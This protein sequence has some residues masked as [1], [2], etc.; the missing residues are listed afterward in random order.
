MNY[1]TLKFN[2]AFICFVFGVG[3]SLV[4]NSC[5]VNSATTNEVQRVIE[6]YHNA[7]IAEDNEDMNAILTDTIEIKTRVENGVLTRSEY[8]ERIHTAQ[9]E[10]ESIATSN[11]YVDV[12]QHQATFQSSV[13]MTF[14]L[15]GSKIVVHEENYIYRLKKIHGQWKIYWIEVVL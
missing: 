12:E 13:K 8:L 11:T 9:S 15:N 6:K 2:I 10:L 14:L 5:N 7:L 1:L 4:L 3:S